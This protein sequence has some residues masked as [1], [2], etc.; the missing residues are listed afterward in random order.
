MQRVAFQLRVKKGFEEA[1]DIAHKQV[2]PELLAEL[3]AFGVREYSIFRRQQELF[4]T[5]RVPDFQ[6]FLEQI[7][8]SKVDQRW[9]RM[10]APLLEAVPSLAPGEAL[11]VMEEVFYMPGPTARG[12]DEA[13]HSAEGGELAE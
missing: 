11:A 12:P 3:Q 6:V 4:L 9:Q 10:M 13:E 7:K 8:R 1:Y 2:W 5:M